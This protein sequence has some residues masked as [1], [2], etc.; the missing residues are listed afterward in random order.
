[1]NIVK[2][3]LTAATTALLIF[4]ACGKIGYKTPE[5]DI[6]GIE[7]EHG[8]FTDARDGKIYRTVRIG[9]QT[10]MAENLN[11]VIDSS[12]CYDNV[13]SYC[14]NLGR[15][16]SWD[17]AM[18]ACPAGWRLPAHDDWHNLVEIAGGRIA[19]TTLK[20]KIGWISRSNGASG[21]GT[22]NF[23]FSAIPGGFRHHEGGFW[24]VM[25]HG[26]WWSTTEYG[27]DSI[28]YWTMTSHRNDVYNGNDGDEINRWFFSVRCVQQ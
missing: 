24:F 20:S 17:A 19:G 16:Y 15:L 4:I 6:T 10:W 26:V 3:V 11:F 21:D 1:V 9:R 2:I 7:I 13:A 5:F 14:K 25:E 12:G 18:K 23:G 22:D 28:W 27:A 8:S